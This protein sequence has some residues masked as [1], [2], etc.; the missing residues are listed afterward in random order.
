MSGSGDESHV[1]CIT[2][3]ELPDYRIV[4]VVLIQGDDARCDQAVACARPREIDGS[5]MIRRNPDRE[6]SLDARLR[7]LNADPLSAFAHSRAGDMTL[8]A[9]EAAGMSGENRC[10]DR[11]VTWRAQSP[12]R[13]RDPHLGCYELEIAAIALDDPCC[14][15]AISLFDIRLRRAREES[16]G[17]G[18]VLDRDIECARLKPSGTDERAAGHRDL[19]ITVMSCDGLCDGANRCR[20]TYLALCCGAARIEHQDRCGTYDAERPS[21]GWAQELKEPVSRV[22]HDERIRH[23]T[24]MVAAPMSVTSRRHHDPW[25]C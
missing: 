23:C 2:R 16:D 19:G 21:R 24:Q 17:T 1:P 9:R 20:R 25:R 14:C 15:D 3:D 13:L 22:L 4:R 18:R 8:Y 11:K 6:R 12:W 10:I 5:T 7:S